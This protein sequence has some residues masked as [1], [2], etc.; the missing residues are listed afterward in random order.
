MLGLAMNLAGHAALWDMDGTLVD[1]AEL[2]FAAWARLLGE[3]GRDFTRQ[4]FADTFGRRNPEIFAHLF[5]GA[6]PFGP[7]E[8]DRLGAR[9]EALYREAARAQGVSLLPGVRSW[10]GALAEAGAGQ[11]I[12]SSAPRAN[13]ELILDLTGTRAYF[14]ALAAMEDTQR[15]KPDPEVFLV[16]AARLGVPHRNCVVLEDAPAGVEA[17]KAAGMRCIGVAFVGHHTEARLRQA[18]ADLAI[19]SL[20]RT[21]VAVVGRLL[22]L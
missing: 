17:A 11:A 20:E 14:G 2:H 22:G 16:A 1:T 12:G 3:L 15:G 9:K 19:S 4:D 5:G 10:L 18:G 21:P 7:E 8:L 13:L 6:A